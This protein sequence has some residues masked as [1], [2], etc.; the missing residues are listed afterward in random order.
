MKAFRILLIVFVVSILACGVQTVSAQCAMCTASVESNAS[1]GNT[2]AKG[3]NH[4]IMYLL[5]T[6]YI[7][8]GVLGFIWYKKYRRKNVELN[9]RDEKLHLN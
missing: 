1:N 6:P 3:L 4:G 7:A 2:T 9:M 5:A 8:V